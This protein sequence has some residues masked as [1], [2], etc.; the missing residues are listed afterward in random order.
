MWGQW[1]V[2]DHGQHG[3]SFS[4]CQMQVSD[5]GARC[6]FAGHRRKPDTQLDL[7][8]DYR[9][10]LALYPDFQSYFRKHRPPLLA[11][12]GRHYPAF[13]PAGAIAYQRDLP[14][15]EVH[16]LDAGFLRWKHIIMRSRR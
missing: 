4:D 3:A 12:W 5:W 13:L 16:L 8:L 1:L 9:S 11:A 14:D 15:V 7:I 6:A 2:N 10:N